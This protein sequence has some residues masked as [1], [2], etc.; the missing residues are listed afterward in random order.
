MYYAIIGDIVSSKSLNERKEIQ[1]KLELCL[2]RLNDDYSH[3][4]EKKLSITLGDEFQGLFNSAEYLL[5]IIH[6]IELMMYPSQIRFGIG[7]GAIEF[8]FGTADSPYQSDGEVW[9]NAREAINTV[10]TNKSTNKL[11]DFSNICIQSKWSSM[12]Q[13]LNHV[14]DLCYSIKDS[15]SEKQ[16]KLIAYTIT[17]YGLNPHFVIKDVANEFNQSISTIFQKYKSARYLNYVK[18]LS[19][20][21]DVFESEGEKQ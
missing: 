13:H 1:R 5:E 16:R 3:H 6:K 12:N 19:Q 11:E 14:L 21:M 10:K 18:V 4:I 15:W 20:L 17:T 9:W 8:D 7:V 2:S